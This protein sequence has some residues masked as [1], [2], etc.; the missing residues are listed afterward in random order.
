MTAL[1]W[2]VVAAVIYAIGALTFL[3]FKALS[4]RHPPAYAAP[5]GRA[6]RGIAYALGRGLL[7][8]EKES[9]RLHLAAYL[10]GVIYHL[11]IFAG[12]GILLALALDIRIV[13]FIWTILRLGSAVGLA[14]GIGLLAK[15][16]LKPQSRLLSTP[17][18]FGANIFVDVFLA[19]ALAASLRPGLVPLF[20][21]Y[22][23]FLLIYIPAGKIR[24][25]FF[26]FF[27]RIF[28]GRFFGRR[29]TLPPQKRDLER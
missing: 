19:G 12:F 21:G 13:P 3:V 7:P 29:G 11:G 28:F 10:G 27:S 8:W 1:R 9:A 16:V 15:R 25:C 14:A 18:D 24:H 22:S 23:I 4:R 20:F 5:Q 2:G 6:S 17:D 26:F